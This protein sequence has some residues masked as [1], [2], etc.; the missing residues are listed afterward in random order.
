MGCSAAMTDEP[1][2][3]PTDA[4]L[5]ILERYYD[6]V[7][8]SRAGAEEVGPFTLFVATEGWPY[9][10][11]PRLGQTD[12]IT[13]DD[14]RRLHDRQRELE[15]PLSIE[16]VDQ[17]TPGLGKLLEQEEIPVERCPLLVLDGEPR[18]QAGTARVLDPDH[19]Q[20][21]EDLRTS[22]AAVT[23][24]FSNPGTAAGPAGLVERDQ[25]LTSRYADLHESLLETMRTGRLCQAA[26][27]D[28]HDLAAGPV[29]G[30]SYS[31][32]EGVAEIAGVGVLPAYRRRGLAAQLTYVMA[33]DARERGVTTVF[34]SAQ[35]E[36][37][38]RVYAGIGF[39]RVGT[40][41]ISQLVE[42]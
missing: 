42:P 33:R 35:S 1:K 15:V 14:V 2:T 24:G 41:C 16:W 34:C 6:A 30:G 10:G 17:N 29:G 18:G 25:A 8:R 32:V 3:A 40:A 4:L 36:D 23:V 12:A 26:V 7:P 39:T 27:Y 37:V 11:R 31:P 21:V 20:D 38:A 13:L 22:R 19:P 9:Y 28:E 5:A